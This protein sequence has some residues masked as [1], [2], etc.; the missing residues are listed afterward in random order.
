MTRTDPVGIFARVLGL[1]VFAA[2]IA[3]L[4]VVFRYTYQV[5]QAVDSSLAGQGPYLQPT[6]A[7][8]SLAPAA[9]AQRATPG[10]AAVPPGVRGYAP[11]P[12]SPPAGTEPLSPLISMLVAVGTRL[13]GALVL[14]YLAAMIAGKGAH[15]TGAA[16]HSGGP[17]EG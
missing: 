14:G 15:L 12:S 13:L 1:I 17:P 5:F 10:S 4:C 16:L 7:G 8:A 3:L 9:G 6:Y 2:G 11:S